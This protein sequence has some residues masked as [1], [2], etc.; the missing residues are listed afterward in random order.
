MRYVMCIRVALE[1]VKLYEVKLEVW[2]KIKKCASPPTRANI[3]INKGRVKLSDFF[4]ASNFDL[5]TF[6]SPLSHMD[7]QYLN[8]NFPEILNGTVFSQADF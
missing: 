3:I 8:W 5:Q 4:Q 1:A 7:A 6:W 2:W